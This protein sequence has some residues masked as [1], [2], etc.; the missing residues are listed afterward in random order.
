[1]NSGNMALLDADDLAERW[2][3]SKST[4]YRMNC[5]HPETLPPSIKIGNSLRWRREDVESWEKQQR[6]KRNE[7]IRS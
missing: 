4:I 6:D 2:G 3:K 5:Y 7:G 1:M